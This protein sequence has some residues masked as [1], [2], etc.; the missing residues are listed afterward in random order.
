MSKNVLLVEPTYKVNFPSIA[1]MKFATYYKRKGYNVKAVRGTPK[2]YEDYHIINITS[3]FTFESE[4]VIETV[5]YYKEKFP[6]AKISVGGIYASL[7]PEHLEAATGIKPHVGLHF[8]VENLPPD[9]SIYPTIQTSL[10]YSS[11]GCIN[12]CKYCSVPKHEPV[13][14]VKDTI[15]DQVNLKLPNITFFD[16]NFTANPHFDKIIDELVV[17]GKKVEF[18]QGLDCMLLDEHKIK[19]LS[20]LKYTPSGFVMAYDKNFQWKY[21]EPV[22]T[23]IAKHKLRVTP[24]MYMLYN[25]VETP[26]DIYQR[27]KNVMELS[28]KLDKAFTIYPM[29]CAILDIVKKKSIG[30]HWTQKDLTRFASFLSS[31]TRG[32]I[33]RSIYRDFMGD[34]WAEFMENVDSVF[35]VYKRVREIRY[36]TKEEYKKLTR[37]W[38]N[39]IIKKEKT[40]E[41]LVETTNKER[42]AKLREYFE[43]HQNEQLEETTDE[44]AKKFGTS[45]TTVFN[46]TKRYSIGLIK[47]E[48]G[49]KAGSISSKPQ[50][51]LFESSDV[52]CSVDVLL[53][54]KGLA[55]VDTLLS[56]FK[57]QTIKLTIEPK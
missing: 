8:D 6:K 9:Y 34:N 51:E 24:K 47:S 16:N 12:K 39:A 37:Y 17:F 50:K 55:F 14:T 3:L 45:K 23:M 57:N 48:R 15:K 28:Y 31:F 18:N 32:F 42:I 56:S 25:F 5:N 54:P 46:M 52:K 41:E 7:M 36:D 13:F 33:A 30:K 53:S 35:A 10:V 27:V 29:R 26:D 1:L 21:L 44:V 22:L 38:I 43:E 11:R 4:I 49:R 20:R 2:L 40:M 19:Q